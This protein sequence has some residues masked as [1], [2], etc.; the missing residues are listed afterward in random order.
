MTVPTSIPETPIVCME[1][2]S[3]QRSKGMSTFIPTEITQHVLKTVMGIMDGEQI[4]SFSHWVSYRGFYSFT[5]ICDHFHHISEDIYKYDEY[6][7]NGIK[8]QL[9][10]NTMY[11]IKMFIKWMSERM[12]NDSFI[13]HDEFI[14][15]LTREQ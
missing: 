3:L 13:L 8:Y 5:D 15:S 10:F 6:R 14:T 4:E 7:V 12:K 11:K 9:K 2:E 1:H